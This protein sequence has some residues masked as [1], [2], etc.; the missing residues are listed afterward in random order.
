MDYNSKANIEFRARRAEQQRKRR[1]KLKGDKPKAEG[2]DTEGRFLKGIQKIDGK[3]IYQPGSVPESQTTGGIKVL[4]F[5]SII[6][7]LKCSKI[8]LLRNKP[9][10]DERFDEVD[11]DKATASFDTILIEDG[12]FAESIPHGAKVLFGNVLKSTKEIVASTWFLQ[13]HQ[14][15]WSGLSPVVPFPHTAF[16]KFYPENSELSKHT[17]NSI[18]SLVITLTQIE[19]AGEVVWRTETLGWKTLAPAVGSAMLF[20]NGCFHYTKP[21]TQEGRAALVIFFGDPKKVQ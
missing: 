3:L 9:G 18:L 7:S 6:P 5:E 17:D 13:K 2:R 16:I 1:E 8:A 12:M 11:E 19:P 20:G 15:N 21:H 4:Y 10:A 14:R